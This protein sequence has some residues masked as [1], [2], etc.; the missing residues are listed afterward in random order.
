MSR[1]LEHTSPIGDRNDDL[2][3]EAYQKML[4][5]PPNWRTLVDE[6]NVPVD[7]VYRYETGTFRMIGYGTF[8]VVFEGV[9]ASD[10][11]RVAL[12]MFRLPM[13]SGPD[14]VAQLKLLHAEPALLTESL[15]KSIARMTA[16]ISEVR[17]LLYVQAQMRTAAAATAGATRNVVQLVD[18]FRALFSNNLRDSM[19]D[20][21]LPRLEANP[22]ITAAE[23]EDL[24]AHRQ[25]EEGLDAIVG[26]FFPEFVQEAV[27]PIFFIETAYGHGHTLYDVMHSHKEVA[28]RQSAEINLR[29]ALDA[30][31]A[32]AFLHDAGL[33]HGDV[34]PHNVFV[35]NI[36]EAETAPD[37]V[38][39]VL[40][41]L[42]SACRVGDDKR[43]V[44]TCNTLGGDP[45]FDAPTLLAF[46]AQ[47]PEP[48][49]A[50]SISFE[51]RASW[52]VYA[53]GLTLYDWGR[54]D[55]DPSILTADEFNPGASAGDRARLA[56]QNLYSRL[57]SA[58][59]FPAAV[60]DALG[61]LNTTVMRMLEWDDAT[62]LSAREAATFLEQRFASRASSSSRS[63]T[64]RPLG[65]G[66][67]GGGGGGEQKVT[68][69]TI[70]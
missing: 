1:W 6:G 67:G 52:D 62:R 11:Q 37:A 59:Y 44:G 27:K 13:F 22:S 4:P 8:S 26:A 48:P 43:I 38:S 41:D 16:A 18:Y 21:L 66:G 28:A 23:R 46:N 64:K 57:P 36:L 33:L 14:D 19:V 10:K 56:A 15:K 42:G 3:Q 61:T 17:A 69:T 29:I 49:D 54:A 31:R 70:P 2:W 12:K 24:L 32:L 35:N 60:D 9:R 45:R 63:A 55:Y 53:L 7:V 40:I 65:D 51:Q 47:Q 25:S 30:L 39:V 68:K 34:K 58:P 5:R 20:F 50:S